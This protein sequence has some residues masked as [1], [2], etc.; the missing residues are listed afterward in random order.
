MHFDLVL[1]KHILTVLDSLVGLV[2][3]SDVISEEQ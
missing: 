1:L 2:A 3:S